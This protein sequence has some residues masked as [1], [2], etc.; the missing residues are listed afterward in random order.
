MEGA[1]GKIQQLD[2][3]SYQFNQ[4]DFQERGFSEKQQLGLIAQNLE[5]VYPELVKTYDDGY[6]AVNYDGLI[7]V[8]IEGLKEQQ[9]EITTLEDSNEGLSDQVTTLTRENEESKSEWMAKTD[10]FRII[11]EVFV[12]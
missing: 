3:V 6:K 10:E 4:Q 11:S 9:Q 5:E 2:G 1:L 7:P 12:P 8:L